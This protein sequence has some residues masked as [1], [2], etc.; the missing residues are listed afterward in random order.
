M[1]RT[2]IVGSVLAG[3]MAIGAAPM[4]NAAPFK[5]CTQ[6]RQAGYENIPSSS[7]YYGPWLDRDGDGVGCES[8]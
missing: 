2:V 7:E 5:N 1:I 8:S 3:A 6:A 4:A